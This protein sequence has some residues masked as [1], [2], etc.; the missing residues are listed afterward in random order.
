MRTKGS[1]R[2]LTWI[3][4]AVIVGAY[5]LMVSKFPHAYII[6]TYEDLVGEWAQVFLFTAT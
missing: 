4:F 5:L 1:H 3:L 6:A 2:Q